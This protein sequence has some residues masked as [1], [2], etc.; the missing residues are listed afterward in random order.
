MDK[1]F[2]EAERRFLDPDSN[3]N[4][5]AVPMWRYNAMKKDPCSAATEQEPEHKQFTTTN[6]CSYYK[7]ILGGCQIWLKM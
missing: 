2:M 1:N 7:P 5:P 6:L 4:T 3:N